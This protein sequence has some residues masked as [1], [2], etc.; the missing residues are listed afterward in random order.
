MAAQPSSLKKDYGVFEQHR[1]EWAQQH[2]GEFV[3]V[4]DGREAG[5]YGDYE[6]AFRAGLKKFGSRSQ[7]LVQQ[8]CAIEPVFFIY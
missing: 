4:F 1:A 7:F 5:F 3:L 2:Q 8:V 6:S